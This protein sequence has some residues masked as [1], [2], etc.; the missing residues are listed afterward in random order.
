LTSLECNGLI[1]KRSVLEKK[2]Q[3]SR[4]S[5]SV[6]LN[7]TTHLVYL[8]RSLAGHQRFEIQITQFDDSE[9]PQ[10]DVCFTDYEPRIKAITHKLA[11]ANG[12]VCLF[13]YFSINSI[14]IKCFNQGFKFLE[15]D[16][17]YHNNL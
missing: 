7:I 16:H 12:K 10:T 14:L 8:R 4:V 15:L 9:E 1:V 3:I 2:K 17:L 6:P 11:N 5:S 13:L